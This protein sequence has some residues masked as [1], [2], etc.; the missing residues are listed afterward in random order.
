VSAV[1]ETG[2]WEDLAA[3]VLGFLGGALVGHIGWAVL[4]VRLLRPVGRTGRI[5][6]VVLLTPVLVILLGGAL[7]G[8]LPVSLVL[9]CAIP[10]AITWWAAEPHAPDA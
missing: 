2:N 7:A 10:A 6:A 1:D 8:F 9:L 5:V 4:V 3:A